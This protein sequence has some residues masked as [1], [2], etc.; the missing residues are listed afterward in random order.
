MT[1]TLWNEDIFEE[2]HVSLVLTTGR[3]CG[4]PDSSSLSESNT[5]HLLLETTSSWTEK[6]VHILLNLLLYLFL[7]LSIL[8]CET[9]ATIMP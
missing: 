7:L 5:Y 1:Q 4:T 6:H 2:S 3:S 9:L 8:A